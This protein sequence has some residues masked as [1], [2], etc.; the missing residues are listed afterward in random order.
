[1]NVTLSHSNVIRTMTFSLDAKHL[2]L[3]S[4][5]GLRRWDISD[6]V[7]SASNVDDSWLYE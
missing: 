1:M 6:L 4:I 7:A 3:A 2:Y 5:D